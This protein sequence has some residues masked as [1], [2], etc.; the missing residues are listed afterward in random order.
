MVFI[1]FFEIDKNGN[2][3][4]FEGGVIAIKHEL[5]L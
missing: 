4:D 5:L 3:I 1:V 2:L